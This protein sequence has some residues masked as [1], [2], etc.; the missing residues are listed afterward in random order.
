MRSDLMSPSEL[1][2]TD[3]LLSSTMRLEDSFLQILGYFRNT[4]QQ[5]TNIT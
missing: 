1:E 4:T 5:N 2:G 3:Y